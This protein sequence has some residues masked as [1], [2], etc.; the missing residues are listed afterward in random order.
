MVGSPLDEVEVGIEVAVDDGY[1]MEVVIAYGFCGYCGG[2]MVAG[3]TCEYALLGWWPIDEVTGVCG[4]V[5][6]CAWLPGWL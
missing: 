4:V 2:A 1:I 5:G 6:V 3:D